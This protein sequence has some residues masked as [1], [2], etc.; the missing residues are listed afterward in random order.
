VSGPRIVDKALLRQ[1]L[2]RAYARRK[3]GADFL[4]QTAAADLLE[5]LS[6][7]ER[8]FEDA[9]ALFGQTEPLTAG[10]AESGKVG[11]VFALERVAAA[12]RL[13]GVPAAVADEEALPLAEGSVDLVVSV[14]ALHW[15]NDLPGALAQV[16]RAL[17]PDGLFLASLLGGSTL[18]ELRTALAAAESELV[19]GAAPRV[20]PF[21]D[22]RDLGGLLQRAGFAL[23]VTDRD[24]LTVRYGS[25]VDLFSDLK[26][27]GATSPLTERSR[28]PAGR[29]LLARAAELYAE[30][31][32]D[33]DGRLRASFE[34]VSL[35]GWAPHESQ[36][37]PA[38]R[39]SG[40]VSLADVLR[41][42][43]A[44]EDR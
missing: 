38:R 39:G 24:L 10:L 42:G 13:A 26:A 41:P 23:P 31:F 7:I 44:R 28:R 37:Q 17:R 5:R 12:A 9:V 27:M 3:P 1:R 21:A 16:R 18:V 14:L 34:I 40:Q 8:R 20:L 4:N 35:S 22:L 6:A 15:A 19:G 43:P 36:Q 32:A 11:R 30:R 25:A 2:A 33:P 29:R